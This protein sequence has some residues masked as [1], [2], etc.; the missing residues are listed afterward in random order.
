MKKVKLSLMS[1]ALIAA[2]GCEITIPPII[3]NT[4]ET[5]EVSSSSS[6][7]STT[8]VVTTN[9]T[10][11][12]VSTVSTLDNTD[13]GSTDVGVDA[14]VDASTTEQ[15]EG[16]ISTQS[17][18]ETSSVE[19]STTV[20]V[21]NSST[22]VNVP[23]TSSSSVDSSSTLPV[24]GNS[25]GEDLVLLVKFDND[26]GDGIVDLSGFDNHGTFTS[27][28][29]QTVGKFG[30][31][32][33]FDG[34][35]FVTIPDDASLNPSNELTLSAWVNVSSY[36]PWLAPGIIAK[37]SGHGWNN[38][39]SMFLYDNYSMH[40]DISNSE[41]RFTTVGLFEVDEWKHVAVV[42]NGQL[43][44]SERVK[45]YVNGT[46]DIVASETSTTLDA[47]TADLEIGRL[48]GGGNVFHGILDEVAIWSRALSESEIV[49]LQTT[50]LT[51][52]TGPVDTTEDTTTTNAPTSASSDVTSD[53]PVNSDSSEEVTS[54]VPATT[55]PVVTTPSW[56]SDCGPAAVAQCGVPARQCPESGFFS[57]GTKC[58]P[59]G[60]DW[61]NQPCVDVAWVN[62]GSLPDSTFHD[63]SVEHITPYG[64]WFTFTAPYSSA[65]GESVLICWAT[66][67][68]QLSSVAGL[69]AAATSGDCKIGQNDHEGPGGWGT[70]TYTRAG[71]K[72]IP[73]VLYDLEPET[74]Y[75]FRAAY[76][77]YSD[78][79]VLSWSP[80][81]NIVSFTTQDDPRAT[82]NFLAHPRL[83]V[84]PTIL[85]ELQQR[86]ANNDPTLLYWLAQDE[87]RLL[88]AGSPTGG[89]YWPQNYA[90]P[91]AL[92]WKITGEQRYYDAAMYN[93]INIVLA[94]YEDHVL[95][96]NYYRWE[97][98]T[99]ATATDLMWDDLDL[100]T[101][102]RILNA[103]LEDDEYGPNNLIRFNDTDQMIAFGFIQA[104]HGMTFL[105]QGNEGLDPSTLARMEVIYQRALKRWYGSYVP[106]MR[107]SEKIHALSGGSMDD[108]VDYA[109]GT[110][111]YWLELMWALNNNGMSH[112]DYSEWIWN[113]F[114][115]H[116][117][118]GIVPG[119]SG[120]AT[121][122]D[123]ERDGL[124]PDGTQ[125]VDPH[126]WSVNALSICLLQKMCRTD[127]AAMAKDVLQKSKSIQETWG[128]HYWATICDDSTLVPQDF[129]TLPTMFHDQG[130][131]LVYD[132]TDWSPNASY[133]MF[134][135]GWR[136][137]DHHHDDVGHFSLWVDGAFVANEFAEYEETASDHNVLLMGDQTQNYLWQKASTSRIVDTSTS[138]THLYILADI[139]S[140]YSDDHKGGLYP[141]YYD[142]V[143]RTLYWDKLTDRVVI[144][145]RVEGTP[146]FPITQNIVGDTLTTQLYNAKSGNV[147]ELLMVVN[148]TGTLNI[149]PNVIGVTDLVTFNRSTGAVQ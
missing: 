77:P 81:S 59:Y 80:L 8:V 105:G 65:Y 137:I 28:V 143:T 102:Q 4:G 148:G 82:E 114:K 38:A 67:A 84:T 91:A 112:S 109:R 83:V 48:P 107:R 134:E 18:D 39:Y 63:L 119:Y 100:A 118:Y 131:G 135:A 3:I 75:Y 43:A 33:A 23:D 149:D 72:T 128:P 52:G 133:L 34:F 5:T 113:N 122:G 32:A 97:Y 117:I 142:S 87:D 13:A 76:S 106:K 145:D 53:A 74:K 40:V 132:R 47:S 129:T 138:A 14:S 68:S 41:D 136:N 20:V 79:T 16:G 15:G 64:G 103:M 121:Y 56:P 126:S 125:D 2:M 85:A 78:N 6:T 22:V 24:P 66:D 1:A 36:D 62:E 46:L 35:G 94:N 29:T 71:V 61:W 69:N 120:A 60:T 58:D 96:G 27:G 9:P 139:T 45:V 127:E 88:R 95:D 140:A 123:I 19:Q 21:E 146:N 115:S 11:V 93:L 141:S 55:G 101:K 37:R 73:F 49:S 54:D 90:V 104:M 17:P 12:D 10:S 92:A 89:V 44:Q 31:G 111:A 98:S 144:Y 86:Y 147:S 99:L 70:R 57:D 110:K 108:G 116:N 130:Y 51:G 25:I 42:F 124:N 50:E 30:N 7:D 26:F